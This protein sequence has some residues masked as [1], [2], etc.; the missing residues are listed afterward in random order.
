MASLV[1][2]GPVTRG[3]LIVLTTY[4][5]SGETCDMK[6]TRR[7]PPNG[8]LNELH[9]TMSSIWMTV[10]GLTATMAYSPL[11][12]CGPSTSNPRVLPSRENEWQLAQVGK[13]SINFRLSPYHFHAVALLRGS[14][15]GERR[16]D[17]AVGEVP[18][19]LQLGALV[20]LVQRA[21]YVAAD[22]AVAA[23]PDFQRHGPVPFIES[24]I[25]CRTCSAVI[26]YFLYS[27]GALPESP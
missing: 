22:T 6:A 11:S 21:Q 2:F 13:P 1:S 15:P 3:S 4:F 23:N 16:V 27:S 17:H 10:C 20:A 19:V 14:R 24:S 25:P 8:P 7:L 26:P 18:F 5:P 9:F 12:F